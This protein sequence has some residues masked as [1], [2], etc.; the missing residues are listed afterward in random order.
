MK[1]SH[2]I[3]S[4]GIGGGGGQNP[5]KILLIEHGDKYIIIFGERYLN[6]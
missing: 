4:W 2:K 3:K 6:V 5:T 1:K